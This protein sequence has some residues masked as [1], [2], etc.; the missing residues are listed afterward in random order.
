MINPTPSS[1]PP[2]ARMARFASTD[3]ARSAYQAIQDCIFRHEE[4]ELSVYNLVVAQVPHVVVLGEQQG[5]AMNE[6][7][8]HLLIDGEATH[9][10]PEVVRQLAARRSEQNGPWSERHPGLPGNPDI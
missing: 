4:V 7:F 10:P 8:N 2:Y 3:A 6:Q 9:L 5:K 1:L